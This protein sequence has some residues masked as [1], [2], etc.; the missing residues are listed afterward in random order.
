MTE[1]IDVSGD[2]FIFR[3]PDGSVMLDTRERQPAVSG[4]LTASG[5][6]VWPTPAGAEAQ[7]RIVSG[8]YQYRYVYPA[9]DLSY[10]VDLGA[11]PAGYT[12]NFIMANFKA[13]RAQTTDIFGFVYAVVRLRQG[14]WRPINAG[15]VLVETIRT[16]NASD[17]PIA[18]RFCHVAIEAGRW[19]LKLR[20]TSRSYQS[21]WSSGISGSLEAAATY[22]FD[23]NLAFGV[24]DL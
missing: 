20:E 23:L 6:A 18:N 10:T 11:A 24:F 15:S 21:G 7:A 19:V 4:L 13:S 12:P 22:N 8:G 1:L 3:R 9:G 5:A 2:A 17:V 14:L 16:S